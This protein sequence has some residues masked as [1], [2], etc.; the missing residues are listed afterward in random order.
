M[1]TSI[2]YIKAGYRNSL[3]DKLV[4]EKPGRTPRRQKKVDTTTPGAEGAPR[5]ICHPFGRLRLK[6]TSDLDL[7]CTC[8]TRTSIFKSTASFFSLIALKSVLNI[9]ALKV[10][11]LTRRCF[12]RFTTLRLATDS[13]EVMVCRDRYLRLQT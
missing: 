2:D 8:I 9:L 4:V 13:E 12:L 10:P 6:S 5:R 1:Q 3:S 7:L 11:T